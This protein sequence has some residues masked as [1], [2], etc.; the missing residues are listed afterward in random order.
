M[1]ENNNIVNEIFS[2]VADICG[3]AKLLIEQEKY[4][5]AIEVLKV[6]IKQVKKVKT[7]GLEEYYTFD[8]LF[9]FDMFI[10]FYAGFNTSSKKNKNRSKIKPNIIWRTEPVTY[11]YYYCGY[12]LVETGDLEQAWNT[13]KKGLEWNPC[14][15]DL[16]FEMV[17]IL[18][19][20]G[21]VEKLHSEAK[22][23]YNYIFRPKHLARFYRDKGYAFIE[24]KKWEAAIASYFLSLTYAVDEDDENRANGELGYIEETTGREILEPSDEELLQIA[25][26]YKI[27]IG[28]DARL[29]KLAQERC[30]QCV[31]NNDMD[32]AE[33]YH[34]IYKAFVVD[35]EA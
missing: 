30:E 31:N 6:K 27:P 7:Y 23:A 22:T 11:L 28:I 16:R 14:A 34:D 13:F 20:Q 24:E 9:Q 32:S 33:Y 4:S 29:L 10:H 21:D 25:R 5:E 12:A 3:Q 17:N 18:R 35:E 26:N 1:L 19:N 15:L 8:E 2:D